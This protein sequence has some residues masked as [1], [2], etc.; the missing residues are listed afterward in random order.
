MIN[1]NIQKIKSFP[2]DKSSNWFRLL[3]CARPGWLQSDSKPVEPKFEPKMKTQN[4]N[5]NSSSIANNCCDQHFY[6]KFK[7]K[8]TN[9]SDC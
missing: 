8:S 1:D 2:C 5:I 9:Y 6:P 7:Y 4:V 3:F